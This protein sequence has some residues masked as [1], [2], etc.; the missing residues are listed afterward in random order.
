MKKNKKNKNK[1]E[2]NMNASDLLEFLNF[3][4]YVKEDKEAWCNAAGKVQAQIRELVI[5]RIEGRNPRVVLDENTVLSV[6][7]EKL[8]KLA[9]KKTGLDN[10]LAVEKF[11]LASPEEI[12]NTM[13][14]PLAEKVVTEGEKSVRARWEFQRQE[15]LD[16]A[17]RPKAK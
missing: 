6:D 11:H 1:I 10:A 7:A 9:F 13:N 17:M 4:Q 3:L 14:A 8:T 15:I 16:Q 5:S 2:L 12:I